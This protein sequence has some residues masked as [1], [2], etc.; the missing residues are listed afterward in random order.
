M[1]ETFYDFCF[2]WLPPPV[3]ETLRGAH[4]LQKFSREKFSKNT[5]KNRVPTEEREHKKPFMIFA[6][7]DC[8]PPC[9]KHCVAPMLS[10]EPPSGSK[11]PEED[12]EPRLSQCNPRWGVVQAKTFTIVEIFG[13][14]RQKLQDRRVGG[15]LFQTDPVRGSEF[16]T[17]PSTPPRSNTTQAEAAEK[18][19]VQHS[20][21]P[22]VR[23]F[24]LV[25]VW[26]VSESNVAVA[27]FR[28]ESCEGGSLVRRR[29]QPQR[30]KK[31][32]KSR[33]RKIHHPT[34]WFL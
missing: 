26:S 22:C 30:A 31:R 28:V 5:L 3:L 29:Q 2:I 8:P 7:F 27:V 33:L 6:S 16:R 20:E 19:P 25:A 23:E 24:V 15:K 14:E 9:W 18:P 17:T 21:W 34:G 11:V 10:Q 32:T 12:L 4:A 1:Y 13:S